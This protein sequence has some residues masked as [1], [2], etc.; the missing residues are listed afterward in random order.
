MHRCSPGAAG[1]GLPAKRSRRGFALLAFGS[2]HFSLSDSVKDF[3]HVVVPS[4]FRFLIAAVE[5][6]RAR[7]AA[8]HFSA[9]SFPAVNGISV[10]FSADGQ[11]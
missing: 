5:A 9:L 1:V 2:V 11:Y 4:R 8:L 6:A 10:P 3:A 7:L